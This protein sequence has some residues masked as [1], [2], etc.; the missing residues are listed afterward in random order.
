MRRAE[1]QLQP[2]AGQE[3]RRGDRHTAF[4]GT[5]DQI[6]SSSDTKFSINGQTGHRQYRVIHTW[7]PSWI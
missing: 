2:D 5:G 4:P 6:D 7:G 1:R 3:H